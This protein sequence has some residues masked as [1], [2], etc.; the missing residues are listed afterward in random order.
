MP[1]NSHSSEVESILVVL[2]ILVETRV[3]EFFMVGSNF[4]S[5][6]NSISSD[7]SYF[8]GSVTWRYWIWRVRSEEDKLSGKLSSS[9]RE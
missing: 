7:E 1:F 8:S 9:V 3:C 5:T 2:D 4:N 6:L